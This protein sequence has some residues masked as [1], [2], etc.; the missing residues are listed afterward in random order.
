MR[1]GPVHGVPSLPATNAA[2]AT[3]I[4]YPFQHCTTAEAPTAATFRPSRR[5]RSKSSQP[6]SSLTPTTTKKPKKYS[7]TLDSSTHRIHH[8][9]ATPNQRVHCN[10]ITS[11]SDC[12]GSAKARGAFQ[13]SS[14][15]WTA[16][17]PSP[18]PSQGTG[19][20]TH[21]SPRCKRQSPCGPCPEIGS[22]RLWHEETRRK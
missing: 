6:T 19:N 7:P 5:P 9:L 11:E 4:P 22:L 14:R 1:E 3:M 15:Y 17:H 12:R 21:E 18:S 13:H 10:K 16:L 8:P 2:R 20:K